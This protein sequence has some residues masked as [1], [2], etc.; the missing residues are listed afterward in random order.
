MKMLLGVITFG[1]GPKNVYHL[2]AGCAPEDCLGLTRLWL[3]HSLPRNSESYVIGH[4]L[5][6]LRKYTRVK[7]IVTYADPAQGHVGTIYQA[8]N[9]IYTGLSQA[10]PMYHLGDGRLRHSRTFSHVMGTRNIT[11]LAKQGVDI[12]V[13]PTL[14]KHRYLYLLD[15]SLRDSIA[16]PVLPYPKKE[17]G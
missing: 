17:N 4:A 9:W 13:V 11:H 16:V 12:S 3:S 7:F 1:V 10:T 5:R 8:S 14:A 2:V 6:A 15:A